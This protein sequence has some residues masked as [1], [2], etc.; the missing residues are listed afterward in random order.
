MTQEKYETRLFI[1]GELL[2]PE[3]GKT[4]TLTVSMKPNPALANLRLIEQ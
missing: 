3:L 2:Q 4:F 1:N